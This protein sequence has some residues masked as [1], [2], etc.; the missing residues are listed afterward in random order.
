MQILHASLDVSCGIFIVNWQIV[1]S[2][3]EGFKYLIRRNEINSESSFAVHI[4]RILL[5]DRFDTISILHQH[6][7]GEE[8]CVKVNRA[9]QLWIGIFLGN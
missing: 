2:V 9:S 5:L 4:H 1:Y 8:N 3:N 6:Q 7:K